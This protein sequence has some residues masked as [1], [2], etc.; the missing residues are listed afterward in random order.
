[1]FAI[2]VIKVNITNADDRELL[3]REEDAVRTVCTFDDER[4]REA[5]HVIRVWNIWKANIGSADLV[6]LQMELAHGSLFEYL[7]K[8]RGAKTT[9]CP[10]DICDIFIQVLDGVRFCH[11]KKLCH[12][13]IKARNGTLLYERI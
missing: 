12:R 13:D 10:A 5:N 3:K 7:E 2:K 11:G 1:M 4:P 9:T 6:H 8:L